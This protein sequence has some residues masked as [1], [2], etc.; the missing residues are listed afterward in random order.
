M[1]KVFVNEKSLTFSE[2]P[3]EGVKNTKYDNESTFDIAMDKLEN[4][5]IPSLNIFY[6]NLEKLWGLFTHHYDYLEA[7]GGIVENTRDEILFIQRFHKWDLPKGKVEKGESLEETAKREIGEECGVHNVELKDFL[8]TTYHIY[9]VQ[10]HI[11]KATHWYQLFSLEER[12]K[13]VPQKE[14][15]I[16]KV[17]WVAKDDM[18]SVYG[19][20]YKNIKLLLRF[21]LEN[22]KNS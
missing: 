5:S 15:G 11:L 16:E 6:H 7:A 3:R 1:Y 2:A 18:E 21:Y 12:P 14:E 20:T 22:Y 10:R 17:D 9:K 8:M 4:S 19:N 13:L